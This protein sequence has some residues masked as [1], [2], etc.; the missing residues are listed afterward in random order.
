MRADTKNSSKI[1]PEDREGKIRIVLDTKQ[2]VYTAK[3]YGVTLMKRD[4]ESVLVQWPNQ[5]Q[6][7]DYR[8]EGNRLGKIIRV[9]L[10]LQ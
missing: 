3:G 8:V 9:L 7:K 6:M 1:R 10:L 4:T 2:K 5:E